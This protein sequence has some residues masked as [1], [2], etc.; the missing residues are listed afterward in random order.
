MPFYLFARLAKSENGHAIAILSC[1]R[2]IVEFRALVRGQSVRHSRNR[3]QGEPVHKERSNLLQTS[4][5]SE[6]LSTKAFGAKLVASSNTTIPL[7][8]QYDP[9]EPNSVMNWLEPWSS[10]HF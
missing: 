5:K 1:M 6:K 3:S 8:L 10:S 7:N 9:A 2:A 4:L